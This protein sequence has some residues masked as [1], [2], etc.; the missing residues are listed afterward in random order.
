[1]LF[2]YIWF[3]PETKI[4]VEVQTPED[5]VTAVRDWKVDVVVVQGSESGGH[6]AA[7]CIL[8]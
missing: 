7:V 8:F 1:M 3:S 2:I 5:A 4:F 6:G